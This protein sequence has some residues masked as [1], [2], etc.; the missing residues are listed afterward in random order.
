MRLIIVLLIPLTFGIG[1]ADERLVIHENLEAKHEL[2]TQQDSQTQEDLQALLQ[3]RV[4][5]ARAQG[6]RL[7]A[8]DRTIHARGALL[9]FYEGRGYQPAWYGDGG[10]SARRGQLVEALGK[11]RAHGLNPADYGYDQLRE[12]MRGGRPAA[13][14]DVELLL[15]NAFLLYGSHLLHG[16]VNPE[17]VEPEWTAN[18]RQTDMGVRLEEALAS[19]DIGA[20]LDRLAPRQPRYRRLL[21]RYADLTAKATEPATAVPAGPTLTYGSSGE[22]VRLLTQRLADLGRLR[23]SQ[24]DTVFA[25]PVEDAVSAFQRA[26]GLEADGSVGPA[27]LSAL[28]TSN[29]ELADRIRANLERWR[30]LPDTLGHRHIEVNIADYRVDVVEGSRTVL[31]L[32]SIVGRDYRQTP[33]FSGTMRYLVFSPYWHVPPS[34]AAR[35]KLPEQK[36]NSGYFAAQRIRLFD[37]ATNQEVAP[38]SVDWSQVTGADLNR[39]FR[40]RQ[41]PGPWNALGQVKFMFPNRFNVYLHDTPSRELFSRAVRTFSSGC[42]RVQNPLDLAEYLLGDQPA[43]TRSAIERAAAAGSETTVQLTRPLPVHVLYWTAWVGDDGALVFRPDIY[44]RDSR[45]LA[46]LT[47]PPPEN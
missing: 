9:S 20:A 19:R 32:P 30:W 1:G 10:A 45:V 17:S 4:E 26:W 37:Q 41:D 35:D 7:S 22:R 29:A 33:M 14:V 2:G 12:M 13:E 27:T 24:V 5:A 44:G 42:V 3:R 43:W 47:E 16:R 31:T 40:L 39:R 38:T 8:A 25:G 18:R 46:A 23:R 21:A 15:T 36:K 6:G 11:G 34:I 28:N